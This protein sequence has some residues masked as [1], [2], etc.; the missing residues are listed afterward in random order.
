MARPAAREGRSGSSA[1]T[2]RGSSHA[3]R[4]FVKALLFPPWDTGENDSQGP[5]SDSKG[6]D[7]GVTGTKGL[8]RRN[9][10][11]RASKDEFQ[12]FCANTMADLRIW[13]NLC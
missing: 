2:I 9:G 4:L 3:F 6:G 5:D 1:I 13:C 12:A 11:A 7:T 8:G 10:T